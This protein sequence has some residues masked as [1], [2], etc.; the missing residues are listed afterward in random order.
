MEQ[1]LGL[2]SLAIRREIAHL[3]MLHSIY[4]NQKVLPDSVIPK[5]T[6]C[7]GIRFKPIIVRVQAY[8]NYSV[9]LTTH[10]GTF[11]QLILLTL[12]F[13]SNLKKH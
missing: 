10:N 6:T 9:P 3:K 13:L 5:H 2:N 12:T 11:Y 8:N 4:Y 1:N 7:A